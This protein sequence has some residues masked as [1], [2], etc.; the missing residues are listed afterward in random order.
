MLS[1]F[2]LTDPL[3]KC[4]NLHLPEVLPPKDAAELPI[5]LEVEEADRISAR[6][7]S[8]TRDGPTVLS[9]TVN[10][11]A[12]V[13]KTRRSTMVRMLTFWLHNVTHAV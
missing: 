10:G 2:P 6:K 11:R 4:P 1:P 3:S 13:G 5:L 7:A 9:M 12:E 8:L